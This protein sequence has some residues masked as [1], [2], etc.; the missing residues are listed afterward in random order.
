MAADLELATLDCAI[1]KAD[2]NVVVVRPAGG[3]LSMRRYGIRAYAQARS[4][5]HRLMSLTHDIN[6]CLDRQQFPLQRVTLIAQMYQWRERGQAITHKLK[7]P[8]TLPTAW[9]VPTCLTSA[10]RPHTCH[11]LQLGHGTH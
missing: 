11:L 9:G 6:L 7:E 5:H 4:R 8:R 2:G 10:G 3:V 1:V